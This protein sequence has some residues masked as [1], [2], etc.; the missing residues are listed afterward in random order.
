MPTPVVLTDA[1]G[2]VVIASP[3]AYTLLG[4]TEEDG[5]VPVNLDEHLAAL[6][7]PP[8][9]TRRTRISV[10]GVHHELVGLL[11]ES[12]HAVPAPDVATLA[13]EIA[14]DFNNLLGVIMNYATLAASEVPEDSQVAADLREVL[15]A[16]RRGAELTQRLM[17]VRAAARNADPASTE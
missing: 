10:D 2:M 8:R 15:A 17:A 1:S 9:T 12:D 6:A 13:G 16:S 5:R 3:L 4:G 11:A 7:T 14:H